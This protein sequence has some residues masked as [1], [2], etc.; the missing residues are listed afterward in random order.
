M[1]YYLKQGAQEAYLKIGDLISDAGATAQIFQIADNPK[2]VF[3]KFRD[4]AEAR[5]MEPKITQMVKNLPSD[6][7]KGIEAGSLSIHSLA[8]PT[9]CVYGKG[10]AFAG[11]LMPHIDH[12]SSV[13]LNKIFSIKSREKNGISEDL[14]WR[15]YVARN[16]VAVYHTL[17]KAGYYVVDTK[18]ANIRTYKDSPAVSI[19]DCDGFRHRDDTG[20]TGFITEEYIAPSSVGKPFTEL[21]GEQDLFAVSILVF[22]IL[23]NGIHPFQGIQSSSTSFTTQQL[24]EKNAYPY[25]SNPPL[26][27]KPSPISCHE[28]FP[29]ALRNHFDRVF[30]GQSKAKSVQNL[31]NILD[32]LK[33]G[34]G[35]TS[36]IKPNH[37]AFT[38]G[39]PTCFID[40]ISESSGKNKAA[41]PSSAPAQQPPPNPTRP[42][43]R[44]KSSGLGWVFF[45]ALMLVGFLIAIDSKKS[46]SSRATSSAQSSSGI[47]NVSTKSKSD[48]SLCTLA[49]VGGRWET[50]PEYLT[51]V[52]Q[53]KARGLSCGVRSQ[54][55]ASTQGQQKKSSESS[56]GISDMALCNKA[57]LNG[58]WDTRPAY[59]WFVREAKSRG[60][61]CGVRTRKNQT[62]TK[63]I[64]SNQ[65]GVP[66][67]MQLENWGS[68]KG[69]SQK[70]AAV[71]F[72]KDGYQLGIE[73]IGK[74]NFNLKYRLIFFTKQLF[75]SGSQVL[76]I[77]S[78]K[79]GSFLVNYPQTISVNGSNVEVPEDF[80][81]FLKTA[82]F[83]TISSDLKPIEY[84]FSLSGSSKAIEKSV[85][86][87]CQ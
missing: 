1:N 85:K 50:R 73:K 30:S 19:L 51:Y 59:E 29:D 76:T 40:D 46:P 72:Y 15:I 23:N 14:R 81:P 4:S 75:E 17:H 26:V 42:P 69:K 35:L 80:S 87:E 56:G 52:R 79:G 58:D 13:S 24:I 70:C 64:A 68:V 53:A 41:S 7:L 62:S 60:L 2:L 66:V 67:M 12:G 27:L 34:K 78:D 39:C 28:L 57:T 37:Y 33:E 38:K 21:G 43:P 16:L 22:Q 9:H 84:K 6:D 71:G 74:S 54:S 8:W 49:T 48:A 5:I 83:L 25:G 20:A 47:S 3:K 65:S 82:N 77:S 44:K 32:D 45:G 31:L 10:G 11:F 55:V 63:N 86:G 36:C 18:P 61:D